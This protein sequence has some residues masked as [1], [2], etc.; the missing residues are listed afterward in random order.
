[1]EGRV[2]GESAVRGGEGRGK[3]KRRRGE[4]GGEEGGGGRGGGGGGGVN[5]VPQCGRKSTGV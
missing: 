3:N 5:G 2:T 4:E 1:M